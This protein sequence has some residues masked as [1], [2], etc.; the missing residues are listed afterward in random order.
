MADGFQER[1]KDNIIVIKCSNIRNGQ[2]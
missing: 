1:Y 2:K